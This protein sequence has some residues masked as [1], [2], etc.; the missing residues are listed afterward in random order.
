MA[1]KLSDDQI[2]QVR[3]RAVEGIP[4]A[5]IASEFGI[6]RSYI[7]EIISGKARGPMGLSH[8]Q[9][10]PNHAFEKGLTPYERLIKGIK[11]DRV[12]GCWIW[13]KGKNLDGYGRIRVNNVKTGAHRLS[14]EIH[15]GTIPKGVCVLH[16]CDT[17]A[18]CNPLHLTLGSH[19]DNIQDMMKKGRK[20]DKRGSQNGKAKINESS[21]LEIIER[22]RHGENRSKLSIAYGLSKCQIS[23]IVTGRAWKHI[24]RSLT[25]NSENDTPAAS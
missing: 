12:T 2:L 3:S 1:R 23:A 6:S 20:G 18:C 24:P 7:P 14:Y 10:H 19:F 25:P 22:S 17:P 11:K 13:T 16:S 9:I 8:L 4:Y 5:E 21:V 15:K